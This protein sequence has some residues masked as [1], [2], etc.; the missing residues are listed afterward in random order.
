MVVVEISTPKETFLFCQPHVRKI[1]ES[2]KKLN[3]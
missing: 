2:K 1:I 3:S